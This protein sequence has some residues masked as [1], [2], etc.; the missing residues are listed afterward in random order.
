[1]P[2]AD[3]YPLDLRGMAYTFAFVGIKRL[4]AGQFYLLAVADKDGAP[5]AGAETYRLTV[6][7]DV[8]VEQYWS[9][10]AYDRQ[11]HALIR[12]MD[13][14]SRSSQ[15]PDLAKNPDGSTDIWFGPE[16]AGGTR[17]ELDPDRPGPR[18]R[19]DV[20]PLRAHEGAASTRPG[21]CPTSP[22]PADGGRA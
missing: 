1:M 9:A 13:H 14:A 16:A 7:P 10:T 12:H 17:G 15:L 22:R 20:P 8:P 6:P 21:R 2:S 5:L 18:L 4:G 3:A 19:G 11:T